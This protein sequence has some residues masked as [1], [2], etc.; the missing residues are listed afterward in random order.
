MAWLGQTQSLNRTYIANNMNRILSILLALTI[1][2]CANSPSE[3]NT[4]NHSVDTPDEFSQF[5]ETAPCRRG[6]SFKLKKEDGTYFEYTSAIAPPVIQPP[7]ISIYPSE[8]I[9]IEADVVNGELIDFDHVNQITDEARTITFEF[10][11]KDDIGSGTGML[12]TVKNPFNKPLRYNIGMM[13]LSEESLFKTSSCPVLPGSSVY[14][15][16]PFPI[17]QLIFANLR[18]LEEGED[19]S[20]VE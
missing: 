9:Y 6:T 17:F 11:Q 16:W 5:C 18:L 2:G 1:A 12:L 10:S 8:V 14:E 13:P 19:L 20:C 4:E 3:I 7:Y 15:H